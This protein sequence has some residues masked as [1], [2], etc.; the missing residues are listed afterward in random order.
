MESLFL[1]SWVHFCCS[2]SMGELA[3]CECVVATNTP[4]KIGKDGEKSPCFHACG[5][6]EILMRKMDV[7]QSNLEQVSKDGINGISGISLFH[8]FDVI[9]RPLGRRRGLKC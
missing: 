7:I 1:S 2:G 3:K 4:K 6:N 8:F 5:I 9:S